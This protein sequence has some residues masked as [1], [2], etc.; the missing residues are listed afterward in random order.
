MKPRTDT[1]NKSTAPLTPNQRI[2]TDKVARTY[3]VGISNHAYSAMHSTDPKSDPV[4]AQYIPQLEELLISN[5]ERIDPTGD[6][7]HSP[8]KG[9]V[10]RYPDR[11]LLKI[12]NICPVYCRYCFRKSMVGPQNNEQSLG[13]SEREAAI[14]YLR[15]TPEIWEVILT[16]GDPLILSASQIGETLDKIEAI[17]HIQTIRVHT[18]TPIATPEKITN[19]M[20]QTLTRNKALYIVLHINHAQELT[21]E[22]ITAI[23][24]LQSTGAALLSQS[25]LLKNINDKAEILEDLFRK[26]VALKVKPYML[27]Q[28][29]AAPGTAHFRVPIEQGQQIMRTLRGK[30]SGLCM[31]EYMLDI[32]GGFG[33]IPLT[34]SYC[35]HNGEKSYTLTDPQGNAHNYP[36]K[37]PESCDD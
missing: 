19:E 13:K 34:P 12:T 24:T 6:N 10:H 17:D 7:A 15:E 27:H 30:I 23:R 29:D 1:V 18:R 9:I 26:L 8:V 37:Q 4:A 31:P 5:P 32:P 21:P 16:G 14:N 22:V 28:L 20:A 35:S 33:K 36:P 2:V 25:V 3:A 11:A